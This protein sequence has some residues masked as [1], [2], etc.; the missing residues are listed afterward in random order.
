MSDTTLLV[1][2][3]LAAVC[4]ECERPIADAEREWCAWVGGTFICTPCKAKV[5]AQANLGLNQSGLFVEAHDDFAFG[6]GH[7]EVFDVQ[8][9]PGLMARSK[10][11]RVSLL[12]LI[13]VKASVVRWAGT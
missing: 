11:V 5:V 1:R 8:P 6:Q 12:H 4:C 9:T 10:V 3:E 13:P 7:R 2:V